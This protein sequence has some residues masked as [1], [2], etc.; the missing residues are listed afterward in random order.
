MKFFDKTLYSQ[1]SA[2]LTKFQHNIS[3][4]Q[5]EESKC[6]A[7]KVYCQSC[8]GMDLEHPLFVHNQFHC[9]LFTCIYGGVYSP[10]LF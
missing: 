2:G 7:K 9:V 3:K 5:T 6:P 8:E 4:I 1:T 10:L